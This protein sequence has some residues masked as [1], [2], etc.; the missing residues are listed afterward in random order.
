MH[1]SRAAFLSILL[2]VFLAG[3]PLGCSKKGAAGEDRT[4]VVE[5]NDPEMNAAIAKARASL[6]KFWKVFE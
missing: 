6:P 3:L 4:T 2:A 1:R 5:E